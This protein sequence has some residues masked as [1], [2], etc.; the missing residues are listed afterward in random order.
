MEWDSTQR[1][2]SNNFTPNI[3]LNNFRKPLSLCQY[4]ADT[5]AMHR[6]SHLEIDTDIPT[7]HSVCVSVCPHILNMNI[8]TLPSTQSAWPTISISTIW[9]I[10]SNL[11]LIWTI[12]SNWNILNI[13]HGQR[14]IQSER[15]HVH[16]LREIL[17]P[18]LS[19]V[20]SLAW[21]CEEERDKDEDGPG[22]VDM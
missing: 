7:T 17:I 14:R 13:T 22:L 11:N 21:K 18:H 1:N 4:G 19:G 6:L 2:R 3:K 20:L 5:V 9:T 10:S 16:T 15:E 8:F 12:S